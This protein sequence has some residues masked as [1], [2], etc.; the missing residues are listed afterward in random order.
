MA[1]DDT[2]AGSRARAVRV[3]PL[4]GLAGR[5]AGEAVV[6][7]LRQR[8]R[9]GDPQGVRREF[10]AHTAEMW[11]HRLGRSRGVL[12]KAGQILS[13]VIPESALEAE[14]R[15]IYQAAFAR[16]L[17]DAPPMPPEIASRV[18]A[19]E[20]GADPSV[21]FAEFD[22]H[23]VA[24]A[25]IGQ[26]HV[27]RLRDGRRVAVKVQ[28]PGV[29]EAIRADLANTELLATFLRLLVSLLP[30]LTKADLRAMAREVSERISEE[31]DYRI[32]AAHQ[33][34]FA[35]AYRG[36]PYIR[37]PE[38]IPELCTRR[39]L[40]M[41]FVDGM[42]YAKATAAQ[43][44]LRD[45]WGEV[46]FRFNYSS[47]YRLRL[48]HTDPHPGNYLFH[49]DG[50]VSFLDF[51][52]V[53][54]FH[55]RQLRDLSGMIFRTLDQDPDRLAKWAVAAGFVDVNDAPD[56][57][58]LLAWWSDSWRYLLAPQPFTIT[59]DYVARAIG[60]RVSASGPLAHVGRK[61]MLPPDFTVGARMDAGLV[62]AIGGLRA[63]GDWRGI[64]E[65]FDFDNPGP[66]STALGERDAEYRRTHPWPA[67]PVATAS[68]TR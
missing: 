11:A 50:T 2:R 48:V 8:R 27:A 42:R 53:K 36:H 20:L 24:A 33:R 47:M 56:P 58:E 18:V 9:D 60:N 37:I 21:V 3:A 38:L 14:Y 28:Y 19:T 34:A 62:A 1:D 63:G 13:I 52:C 10:H 54:K 44:R 43:Q 61:M 17:D 40:T 45:L 65:E 55:G 59:P 57:D 25:S 64:V 46:M 31:I 29:D 32:E 23:P 22:P 4:L 51:G 26:V 16:L 35:D 49:E 5:T 30:G 66:P 12:M 39:V 41:E 68:P 7:A 67:A 15:G 6:A